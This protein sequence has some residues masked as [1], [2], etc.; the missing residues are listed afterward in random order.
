[1]LRFSGG[2]VLA[3]AALALPT[4][5]SATTT[6]YTA[7]IEITQTS[8]STVL[9]YISSSAYAGAYTTYTSSLSN[10]LIVSFSVDSSATSASGVNLTADNFSSP[11]Y[12]YL[13]L[14]EGR[15]DTDGTLSSGSYQYVYLNLTNATAPGATPKDVGNNYSANSGIDRNSESAVWT[16][17]LSTGALTPVWTN[18]DGSTPTLD[19]FT[20]STALYAGGDQSAFNGHY[21]APVAGI[22]LS[23]DIQSEQVV[24][25]GTT[26]EPGSW[27]L[28]GTGVVAGMGAV[29]RRAGVLRRQA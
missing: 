20:Q 24:G 3:A 2:L 25:G 7:A 28:L 9:G 10:A 21:P 19:V 14:V 11:T 5:A 1:M 29:R 4:A 13:G 16:I 6:D 26:P 17:D 22:T 23:L 15:D 18:P 8:D 27:M 12:G